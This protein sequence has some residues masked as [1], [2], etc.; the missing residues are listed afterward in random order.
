MY[1]A[2]HV[3]RGVANVHLHDKYLQDSPSDSEFA[4]KLSLNCA[5]DAQDFP[6]LAIAEALV[7]YL[8]NCFKIRRLHLIIVDTWRPWRY[9]AEQIRAV[10]DQMWYLDDSPA[11][12]RVVPMQPG[13]SPVP[14]RCRRFV[15]GYALDH[16]EFPCY[17]VWPFREEDGYTLVDTTTKDFLSLTADTYF[18]P[19]GLQ[20]FYA[21]FALDTN[22]SLRADVLT[23][24]E[25]DPEELAPDLRVTPT[26]V[27]R[28]R[29]GNHYERPTDQV[30]LELRRNR[31]PKEVITLDDSEIDKTQVVMT[32]TAHTLVPMTVAVTMTIPQKSLPGLPVDD[33]EQYEIMLEAYQ[34]VG[35]NYEVMEERLIGG[36]DKLQVLEG[37]LVAGHWRGSP[38]HSV[39]SLPS[40]T[41]CWQA[42]AGKSSLPSRGLRSP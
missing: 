31:V 10:T 28:K 33:I 29:W 1:G 27:A 15:F 7:N 17:L 25:L 14:P 12:Q 36:L 6:P 13:Q 35:V 8:D 19:L 37:C 26:A 16:S 9:N 5:L 38:S 2:G 3:Y 30:G 41:E 20:H 21:A 23:Q 40:L 42:V 39:W 22:V 24:F 32:P 4:Q 11:C 18:R 34:K